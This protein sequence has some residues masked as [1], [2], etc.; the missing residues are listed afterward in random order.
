MSDGMS[1][2]PEDV[3]M[4]EGM[5]R[6]LENLDRGRSPTFGLV[7]RSAHGGFNKTWSAL[8]R[9]GWVS[10]FNYEITAEG[11]RVLND[12]RTKERR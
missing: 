10:P 3:K 9:R 11:S 5:R 7:G 8:V 6:A 2:K 12:A 4:T 1:D